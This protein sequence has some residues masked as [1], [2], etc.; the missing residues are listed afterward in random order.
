MHLFKRPSSFSWPLGT[1]HSYG[2]S[3]LLDLHGF[4]F[5]GPARVGLLAGTAA[6]AHDVQR[7][8]DRGCEET[9]PVHTE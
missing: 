4:L 2:P 7:C 3:R 1:A 8:Q 9:R 5:A 6:C